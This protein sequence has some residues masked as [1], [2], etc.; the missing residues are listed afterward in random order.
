VR[1]LVDSS[2]K[3]TVEGTLRY[4]ACDDRI[5]YIPQELVVKWVFQYAEFDRERVPVELRRK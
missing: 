3:F 5:C 1:P 2:G 4:Q